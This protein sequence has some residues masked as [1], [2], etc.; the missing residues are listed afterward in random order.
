MR[1]FGFLLLVLSSCFYGAYSHPVSVDWSIEMCDIFRHANKLGKSYM[2]PKD[3]GR[4]R[5]ISAKN[6]HSKQAILHIEGHRREV[7]DFFCPDV[8]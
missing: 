2:N 7:R 1:T 6:G 4:L 3:I 8:W 5:S